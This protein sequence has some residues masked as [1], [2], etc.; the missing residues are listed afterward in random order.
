MAA[1]KPTKDQRFKRLLEA[2]FFPRDLPPPFVAMDFARYRNH[3][4]KELA[5]D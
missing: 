3:L 4:K 2:G 1:I 5:R